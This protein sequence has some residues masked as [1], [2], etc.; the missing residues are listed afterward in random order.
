MV[1]CRTRESDYEFE[2]SVEPPLI[3]LDHWGALRRLSENPALGDRFLGAFAHR[4]TVMFSLM[5][6]AEIARDASPDRARQIRAFLDRL[7]PYWVPMTIDPHRI[8]AAEETGTVADGM[9]P[10][11]SVEFL[12]DPVFATRLA[13]GPVSLAHVVDLT[14]RPDG[15]ELIQAT[16]RNAD[17]LLRGIQD[18]RNAYAANPSDLDKTC[19]LLPFNDKK[20]MRGIYYALARFT[21]TDTFTLDRNHARDL[22]HA[23]AS[24][25]C[26]QMVTLDAHW[27]AQV[28]K[29]R[30]SPGFVRVYSEKD[31]DTFLADIETTPSTR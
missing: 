17:L 2:I 25:R 4:G 11:V 9:R 1:T 5:N 30:L 8:I 31:F 20:P 15:E 24:V 6:A 28:R 29:L 12:T 16:D 13:T 27:A 3:Y 23:I 10:C 14:R 22:F 19:P 7:G 18:R 26:A 21:I